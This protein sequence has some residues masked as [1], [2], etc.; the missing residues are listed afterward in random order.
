MSVVKLQTSFARCKKSNSFFI[1]RFI[2]V[3]YFVHFCIT[4]GN[5][6][7]Y[8]YGCKK[9]SC[10]PKYLF[11]NDGYHDAKHGYRKDETVCRPGFYAHDD[12]PSP[13]CCWDVALWNTAWKKFWDDTIG[14][15]YY[16]RT[17]QC[18]TANE[19]MGKKLSFKKEMDTDT[20]QKPS[21]ASI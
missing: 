7:G 20:Y 6:Y 3:P 12:S 1:N 9:K 19:F 13:G 16:C 8:G 2:A 4:S 17:N 18:D 21:L 5:G 11:V 10:K 15:K 14:L